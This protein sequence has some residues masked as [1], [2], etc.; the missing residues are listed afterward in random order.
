MARYSFL[1]H[2]GGSYTC[3]PPSNFQKTAK[4]AVSHLAGPY[5]VTMSH[6]SPYCHN[7]TWRPP[8]PA[9]GLLKPTH[10]TGLLKFPEPTTGGGEVTRHQR[11]RRRRHQ[12]EPMPVMVQPRA[13]PYDRPEGWPR[14]AARLKAGNCGKGFACL[15]RVCAVLPHQACADG[16]VFFC[17][18]LP[19]S[20]L[21]GC[22]RHMP[23]VPDP[24]RPVGTGAGGGG[25]GNRCLA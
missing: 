20:G 11:R 7:L 9:T 6:R 17:R 10:P 15:F 1:I 16:F 5:T 21:S 25:I 19:K 8:R 3:R 12:G 24:S 13:G 4:S 23:P 22:A 18:Q 14:T 2:S